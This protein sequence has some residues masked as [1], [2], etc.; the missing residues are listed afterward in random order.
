MAM[1]VNEN[2]ECGQQHI[3]NTFPFVIKST[4]TPHIGQMIFDLLEILIGDKNP[5][6]VEGITPLQ[7][8]VQRGHSEIYQLFKNE[9]PIHF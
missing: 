6:N 1:F 8:A 2:L 3:S 4:S 7:L 5:V 9:G